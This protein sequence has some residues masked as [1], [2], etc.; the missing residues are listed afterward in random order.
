M[1]ETHEII[2]AD[3]IQN[4]VSAH[5]PIDRER[6]MWQDESQLM[7]VYKIPLRDLIFNK[8]NGRI[9]S[10]VKTFESGNHTINPETEEGR[11][12]IKSFLWKSAEGRNRKTE[13]DLRAKGQQRNAIVTLDGVIIDGNRRSML[14]EK[15]DPNG[16]VNAAVLPVRNAED[17]FEIQKLEATYQMGVD[18]KVD[19]NPIEK[20]IKIDDLLQNTQFEETD[21]ADLIGESPQKI[22]LMRRAFREMEAYLDCHDYEGMYTALPEPSHVKHRSFTE[23]K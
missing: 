5:D 2:R 1:P 20:Y 14:L 12:L 19:Y 3:R 21:V 7:E 17:P 4:I 23:N 18:A 8:Y 10:R 6:I 11:T 9:G 16:Y 13:K 15:I 22:A